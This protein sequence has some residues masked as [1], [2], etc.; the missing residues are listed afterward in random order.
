MVSFFARHEVDKQGEGFSPG[1]PGYP[2]N[3]RIAWALWGGD[4]GKSL[5]KQNQAADGSKGQGTMKTLQT[6]TDPGMFRTDRLPAPPVRVD[7]K[8]NVIFGASLMQVGN[9]NDAEVRPWTVDTKTLDQAVGTEHTQ[10][11]WTESPIHSPEYVCR[12]HGQLFGPLE[13]S[14]D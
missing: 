10:P 5:V 8:A 11:E 3:G 13:E 9:L 2:S 4:P 14:A 1:E 6:L 12:W 7:R